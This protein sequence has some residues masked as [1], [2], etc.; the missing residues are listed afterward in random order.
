MALQRAMRNEN[1]VAFDDCNL[2]VLGVAQVATDEL[3]AAQLGLRTVEQIKENCCKSVYWPD[4]CQ[5]AKAG[6]VNDDWLPGALGRV[7][8]GWAKASENST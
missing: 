3:L 6:Q 8:L 1:S 7:V 4:F 2:A 5:A